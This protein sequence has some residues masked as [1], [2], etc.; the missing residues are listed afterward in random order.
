VNGKHVTCDRMRKMIADFLSTK[1]MT[2]TAFLKEIGCYANTYHRFMG[3]KGPYKGDKTTVYYR[4]SKFFDERKK[5]EVEERE[6]DPASHKRKLA[7]QRE[8]KKVKRAKGDDLLER[9]EKIRSEGESNPLYVCPYGP[10]EDNC[11]VVRKKIREFLNEGTV[12]L[13]GWLKFIGNISNVSYNNFMSY[14]GS[15]VGYLNGTYRAA[16]WFF[17]QKRVMEGQPK[18]KERIEK[19]KR[20]EEEEAKIRHEPPFVFIPKRGESS[21]ICS[22]AE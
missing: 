5:K 6:R 9:M 15:G 11:D 17:E 18:S 10:V 20:L 21:N 22:L 12:T 1:E 2:Q 4:A 7:E 14:T 8:E 19:E 3:L 13:T 16:Y